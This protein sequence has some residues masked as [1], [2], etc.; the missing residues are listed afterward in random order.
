ML[1]LLSLALLTAA[2]PAP[3]SP[4]SELCVSCH[5]DVH[6]GMVGDWEASR[7]ARTT[8]AQALAKPALE[9]RMSAAAV[10]DNL[11]NVSVGCYECHGLRTE[12]HSDSFE[13]FG[14]EVNVVVTP[15]DCATCHADEA[16]QYADSK[17][18]WALDILRENSVF[19]LL[20]QTATRSHG[21]VDGQVVAGESAVETRNDACYACH[22]TEVRVIGERVIESEFGEVTVPELTGWPNQGVGRHNP[23]GSRG[24]CTSC[25]PRHGFSLAV[26]RNPNTCAQC[27]L[28]PDVPAFEVYRESKHGNIFFA[29]GQGY[30]MEAVPWVPGRDFRAPTCVTCHNSLLATRDGRVIAERSHDFGAR[31]WVRLFGLPYAHPQPVHGRTFELRNADGQPLPTTFAGEPAAEGLLSAEQQAERRERMRNVCVAC[32]S[33][34]WADDHFAK[35]D[36][37]VAETNAMTRAATTLMQQIWDAGLADPANPFDEPIERTW[38][39]SWLFHANSIR[40]GVAM[41]GPD[42]ATF[43][44]GWWSLTGDLAELAEFLRRHAE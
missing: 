11:L 2:P 30:D 22:G 34:R 18:A 23:D 44:N 43:K 14:Y 9:R 8:P 16:E 5:L 41:A 42:Y 40:L 19:D 12:Q 37:S 38:V 6:P 3:L 25:H 21:V 17:K 27:H 29:E 4:E 35:I 20:V 33:R 31:L 36:R 26:A 15:D 39:E 32:H 24:A 1:P 28:E 7:H 13:H 10:P